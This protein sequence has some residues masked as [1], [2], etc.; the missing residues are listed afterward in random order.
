MTAGQADSAEQ[1]LLGI[2]RS[3]VERRASDVHF[4]IYDDGPRIRLRIDG[5]LSEVEHPSGEE[6]RGLIAAIKTA[7]NLELNEQPM[8]Q[9]GRIQL[10]DGIDLRVSIV[11]CYRGEAVTMR[12]L[13]RSQVCLTLDRVGLTEEQHRTLERWITSPNGVVL[14]TGPTGSG[15][16]TVLYSMLERVNEPS[17]KVC[18]I[19]DPIEYTFNGINQLAINPKAG[20]T[21]ASAARA[22]LRQDPDIILVGEIR[23]RDTAYVIIQAAL[24][25]HLV[26]STLHT[27][28]APHAVIRLR[29]I[30]VEPFL[31]KETV[32]GV[33]SQRLIRKLCVHC[34]EEYE[35]EALAIER[36]GLPAG[37]YYRPVGCDQCAGGYRGRVAVLE[38]FEPSS[39][40]KEMMVRGCTEAELRSQAVSDGMVTMWQ[41]AVAKAREGITSIEETTRVVGGLS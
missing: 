10:D 38:L 7:A 16:T 19:E 39:A 31:I 29:D 9:D 23:D 2:I 6:Y 24:T 3:A 26:F 8:L 1:R 15:K 11:P 20:I 28:T 21:F 30:G 18:S 17:V 40:C 22:T 14:V 5:V 35:P 25:G 13:A 37:T 36:F 41:S 32:I 34:R 4:E 27:N 12:I 33:T